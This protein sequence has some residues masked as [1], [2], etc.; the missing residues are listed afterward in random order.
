MIHC[1][2]S[3]SKEQI[4]IKM[5]KQNSGENLIINKY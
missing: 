4:V 5:L 3:L 2:G 1:F